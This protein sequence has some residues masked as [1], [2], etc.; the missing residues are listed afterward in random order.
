MVQKKKRI[1]QR[2]KRKVVK[3]QTYK[4]VVRKPLRMTFKQFE[5][6]QR[7]EKQ[8]EQEKKNWEN[9]T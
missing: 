1:H 3:H 5:Q 7:K 8:N 4:S 9:Q 2:E 6:E